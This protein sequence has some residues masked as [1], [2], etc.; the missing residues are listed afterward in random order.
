[1]ACATVG[2]AD[3][4]PVWLVGGLMVY[5]HDWWACRWCI[6][7]TG[8]WADGRPMWLVGGLIFGL[9]G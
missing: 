7:V 9:C 3:G 6:C 2:R 8:E 5:L 1:M 4:R